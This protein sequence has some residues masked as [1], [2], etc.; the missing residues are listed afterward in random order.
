MRRRTAMWASRR[1]AGFVVGVA[2]A[3]T[4]LAA[5]AGLKLGWVSTGVADSP[6]PVGGIAVVVVAIE[7]LTNGL[8]RVEFLAECHR[9]PPRDPEA[10]VEGGFRHKTYHLTVRKRTPGEP[11]ETAANRNH[12]EI[13]AIELENSPGDVEENAWTVFVRPTHLTT[14]YTQKVHHCVYSIRWLDQGTVRIQQ[15]DHTM[16]PPPDHRV[17]NELCNPPCHRHRRI[18]HRLRAHVDMRE[19]GAHWVACRAG[20]YTAGMNESA[21]RHWLEPEPGGGTPPAYGEWRKVDA[22]Y[23]TPDHWPCDPFEYALN[24]ASP[25]KLWGGRRTEPMVV[26]VSSIE[27]VPKGM[28]RTAP[29]PTPV[30]IGVGALASD[31][32]QA[33]VYIRVE[34]PLAGVPMPVRLL[35]GRGH[36]DDSVPAADAMARLA[37]GGH[38]VRGGGPQVSVPTGPGGLLHGVLTSSDVW[39]GEAVPDCQIHIGNSNKAVRFSWDDY[40]ETNQWAMS[41]PFLP[42]PGVLTNVLTLRH[43]RMAPDAEDPSK[44]FAGHKLRFFVEKVVYEDTEGEERTLWNTADSPSDLS[45]WAS[46]AETNLLTDVQGA[47]T[48]PLTVQDRPELR[49]VTMVAYDWSVWKEPQTPLAQFVSQVLRVAPPLPPDSRK[50]HKDDSGKKD[51]TI[52]KVEFIRQDNSVFPSTVDDPCHMVSKYKTD[53]NLPDTATFEGP[54]GTN[55]D[56]DTFRVQVTGLPSGETPSIRLNVI[57]G[58]I[59]VYPPHTYD[60]VS[61]TEGGI[62]KYRTNKHIRLVSNAVDDDHL[63]HQT[64]SVKLLDEIV[65]TLVVAGVDKGDVRLLVARPPTENG[66]KAVRTV[67][68]HFVTGKGAGSAPEATVDRIS[69]DW[70]QLAIRFNLVSKDEITPV[71]NALSIESGA[72]ASGQLSV[73]VT[74]AGGAAQSVIAAVSNGDTPETMAQKLAIAIS[75]KPGLTATQHRDG[76]QWLVLVNK[77]TDVGF[78][79]VASSVPSVV[80]TDPSLTYED[81]IVSPVEAAVLFLNFCDS[82]PKTIDIVTVKKT[83]VYSPLGWGRAGYD[84]Y[85]ASGHPAWQNVVIVRK[86]TVDLDDTIQPFTAGHEMGHV[87]FDTGSHPWEG[88]YNLFQPTSSTDT[89]DATK[90]LLETQNTDARTDSGPS[91]TPPILQKE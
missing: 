85:A 39:T 3:A 86:E 28:S 17:R 88:R 4:P 66:T 30:R 57:R 35:D 23:S 48:A 78:A 61:G 55:P 53:D 6:D 46:F 42:V 62:L 21:G 25:E 76:S 20:L 1:L 19:S 77:G 38:V 70:A 43:H 2:L 60:M 68:V 37:I 49:S 75:A 65:A 79:N 40:R 32:H 82:D 47:V 69:E 36:G 64:V 18:L 51:R 8:P 34:P 73:D 9:E 50:D 87:L 52:L 14:T 29:L 44:P 45:A 11:P 67:D 24:N 12:G 22:A 7:R 31:A 56:P 5:R 54:E 33:D 41:P 15:R 27:I 16:T 13:P 10:Q 80:F 58:G 59:S 63:G 74:P 91:T 83:F 81:E 89:L 71:A 84:A 90:R 72:T 26:D